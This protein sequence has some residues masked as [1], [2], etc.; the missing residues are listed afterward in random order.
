MRK[1]SKSVGRPRSVQQS[2]KTTIK[3]SRLSPD[4]TNERCENNVVNLTTFSGRVKDNVSRY[5][6]ISRNTL[7]K[8]KEIVN[9]A[10]QNPESFGELVK[11]VDLKK[12][13]V[14][15]AFHEIQKQIKKDQ[16]LASIRSTNDNSSSSNVNLLHGDFRQLLK[17]IPNESIDLIFT[18]PPYAAE[19]VPLYS[20]LAVI[21]HNVLKEGGSLVTYV[22]HYAIPKVIKIMENAGLT[23]WWPIAVV[24]S[25]SFAKHY[26]KQV[27]IKWKPLLWFVKGD[28][29]IY[30]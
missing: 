23:Y 18:D 12:I 29:L 30:N 27:T 22:G 25:G 15:K 6:G 7:E 24:L 5:F 2:D 4:S 14:D 16:I 3:D 26:P 8:E 19:Y 10:E 17:T 9:A 13:S 1:H 21:A 20:D 28:K 11:K